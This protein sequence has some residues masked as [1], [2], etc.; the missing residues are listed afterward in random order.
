MS[1]WARGG[2]CGCLNC[3]NLSGSSINNE[4]FLNVLEEVIA[5]HLLPPHSLLFEI[6]ETVA[7][8]H[9]EKNRQFIYRLPQMGCQLALDV[10]EQGRR[11]YWDS[12]RSNGAKRY[13]G[14]ERKNRGCFATGLVIKWVNIVNRN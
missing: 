13:L 1:C 6:T 12:H 11:V 10:L 3:L 2:Y 8:L 5:S 9:I 4:E 14:Y 7:L